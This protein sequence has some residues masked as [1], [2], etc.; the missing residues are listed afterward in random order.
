MVLALPTLLF[1]AMAYTALFGLDAP[2]AAPL[3]VP[4]PPGIGQHTYSPFAANDVGKVDPRLTAILAA[5]PWDLHVG[6]FISG[7]HFCVHGSDPCRM[8]NHIPGRAMDIQR[9][10]G[11]VADGSNPEARAFLVWLDTFTP[12]PDEVG[13]AFPE[14]DPLPGKWFSDA[15]HRTHI[16][17]GYD[18]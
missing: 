3:E 17:V 13:S 14:F 9:V 4:V 5:S 18:R 1:S 6:V 15:D 7:H 8:S 2:A 11:K 10:A 12:R 16:H